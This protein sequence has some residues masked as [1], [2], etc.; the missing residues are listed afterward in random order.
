MSKKR[1]EEYIPIA[2]RA[3]EDEFKDGKIPSEYNGYI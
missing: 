3:L 1:V 2:S